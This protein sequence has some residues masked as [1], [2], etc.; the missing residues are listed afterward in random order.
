MFSLEA[1]Y[2]FFK[3]HLSIRDVVIILVII[4]L[5]GA[6][7]L[8]NLDNWPIFSD[9]GIYIRWAQVAWKDASWRFISVTDGRQP[10]QTWGTI[11][12]LKLFPQN[13]LFAGRLF[14]VTTG[15]ISLAGIYSFLF[16]LWGKRAAI[17][18]ALLY[19]FLPFTLLYD[20]F[21]LVDSA[22]N[23]G[24]IWILFFSVWLARKQ[25][26]DTALLLGFIGGFALL[27]KSSSRMFL[28]LALFA[29][30]L[31]LKD[32]FKT[33]ISKSINY[34]VLLAGA[35][36]I[37]L[38]FYNV[39][40]L[41]PYFHYVAQKNTTFVMT[42]S[43]FMATPFA[44][45][46]NFRVIPLYIAWESGWFIIPFAIMGLYM[47]Y[48]KDKLLAIY[49]SVFFIV[50]YIAISF[51]AKI[52]FARYV[53]FMSSY[54]ILGATYFFTQHRGKYLYHLLTL[55]FGSM[56][57]INYSLL[58]NPAYVSLPPV[59]RGQYIEGATAVWGAKEFM[60]EVR[61][62]AKANPVLIMA[63]GDF[64]LVGDVLRIFVQDGDAIQI[65]G[66]WPL[67]KEHLV[68]YQPRLKE[69]TVYIVFS[70]REEFPDH[71]PMEF[72][73][74]YDKPIGDKALYVYKLTHAQ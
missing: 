73:R 69:R 19:I 31:Y 14:S 9:E 13:A 58:F 2:Y 37:S 30:I 72:V 45:A 24:C 52:L 38:I 18:G 23:A 15:F 20:R 56:I 49:L 59:D 62:E 71:W 29:P 74:M 66:F 40:R 1:I 3:K 44:Y 12:F 42:L 16:Y 32:S 22:V 48:K 33:I 10:L 67:D 36:V 35:G 28:M 55:L 53:L 64:G 8:I 65:D 63:E 46:H 39:Q 4:G 54:V 11:V 26:L 5:Y 41:S 25:R 47:F 68:K 61:N 17:I 51:F 27:A 34:G 57:F 43:E 7:R 21:A 70:H 50:P 6:F 60:E